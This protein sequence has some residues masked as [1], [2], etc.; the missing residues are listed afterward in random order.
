M[1]ISLAVKNSFRREIQDLRD[2]RSNLTAGCQVLRA[3]LSFFGCDR[4]KVRKFA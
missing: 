3:S 4:E 2:L 1:Q